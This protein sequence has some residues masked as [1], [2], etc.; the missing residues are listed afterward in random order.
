[1]RPKARPKARYDHIGLQLKH[2]S[3]EKIVKP[4]NHPSINQTLS[5][6]SKTLGQSKEGRAFR[7]VISSAPLYQNSRGPRYSQSAAMISCKNKFMFS[8]F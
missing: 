1:M 4:V 2:Y 5:S 6:F 3:L 8:N 7:M